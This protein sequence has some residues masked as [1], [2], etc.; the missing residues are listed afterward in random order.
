ML[1][2]WLPLLALAVAAPT[3]ARDTPALP[4]GQWAQLSIH[5]R[6]IVRLA[7]PDP[8]TPPPAPQTPIRWKEKGR[9]KCV[10]AD[11]L[12]GAIVSGPGSVD[13][14]LGGGKRVRA[15]LGE[16]CPALGYYL[17]FYIKPS[18]DGKVCAA[19]D[20]IRSRSGAVCPIEEFRRLTP[21]R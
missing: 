7:R 1:R 3:A 12:A 16:R 4:G 14:V 2:R 17:G 6:I 21:K 19:R 5:E 10:P 8:E 20:A 18:A 15:R 11:Q 13:L 9:E